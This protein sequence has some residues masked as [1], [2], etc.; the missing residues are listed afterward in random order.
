M[1]E[2]WVSE[3]KLSLIGIYTVKLLKGPRKVFGFKEKLPLEKI[4]ALIKAFY[5]WKIRK[6]GENI[7]DWLFKS[8]VLNYPT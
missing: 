8:T 4:E 6:N 5:Y 3:Q 2:I 1:N 7:M